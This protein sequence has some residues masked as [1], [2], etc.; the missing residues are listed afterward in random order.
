MACRLIGVLG[1]DLEVTVDTG[2]SAWVTTR[3]AASQRAET[4][5]TCIYGEKTVEI[6]QLEARSGK[7]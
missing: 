7:H 2:M 5:P 3:S 1:S 6:D 4:G